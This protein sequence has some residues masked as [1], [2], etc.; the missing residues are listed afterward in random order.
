M[1]LLLMEEDFCP[2]PHIRCVCK[3]ADAIR[4]PWTGIFQSESLPYPE[5]K[6]TG[7]FSIGKPEQTF[8]VLALLSLGGSVVIWI[9]TL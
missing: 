1:G 3:A 6:T 4:A 9:M 8:G 2:S 7:T 5:K